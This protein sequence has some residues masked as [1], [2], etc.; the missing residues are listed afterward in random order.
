MVKIMDSHDFIK[1]HKYCTNHGDA[2][3]KDNICGCFY[4]LK[5]F[6]PS[7]IEKWVRHKKPID[8]R[9]TERWIYDENETAFCPF[10]G[11]DS[12]IGESSGYPI[13]REFLTEMNRYWFGKWDN[14]RK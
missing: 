10:C 13:T 5:I 9:N 14:E 2:L 12:V 3:K 11:V 6:S 7:V 4:C 8:G 1:A